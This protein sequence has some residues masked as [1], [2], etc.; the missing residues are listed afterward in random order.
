MSIVQAKNIQKT[1]GER[2]LL[3]DV[4]F[5]IGE[6]EV[7]GLVGIN[8]SGKTTLM[9]ILAGLE[10]YDSGQLMIK[11]YLSIGLL[12]QLPDPESDVNS[13]LESGYDAELAACLNYIGLEADPFNNPQNLSG[14]ERTRLS[15][16][17]FLS[18]NFDLM[19]LDEP[20]NNMD[21]DGIRATIKMLK[22]QTG[23]MLIVSHDRFFLDQM[24]SRIFELDQGVIYEYEGNY[25]DYR[26]QKAKQAEEQLHRYEAER[27]EQKKIEQAILQTKQWAE[28]AHRDSTKQDDSGLKMG[29]KE[30]KRVKARKLDQKIKSDTKRLE[31]RIKQQESKPR[32]EREV[33]FEI[34]QDNQRG[35][36][37]LEATDLAKSYGSHILF[38]HSYFYIKRGEKVAVYGPNGCGKTTL[39]RIMRQ[40]EQPDQG[41]LWI[42]SSCNPYYL[43]QQVDQ[44]PEDATLGEYLSERVGHLDGQKR[45]VIDQIGFSQRQLGQKLGSMS[46]GERMKTKLLEPILAEKDFLILDEPTNYLDLHTRETLETALSNYNGTLMIV[47]HDI[48]LLQQVCDKTLVFEDSM[49]R[50]YE[51]TFA[52]FLEKGR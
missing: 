13:M 45:A 49:I 47:S 24:V 20:T 1:F 25:S 40:L 36:R 29:V 12:R 51:D 31:R 19:L 9:R 26:R 34:S 17:R 50:R 35:K 23:S 44:L 30:N 46:L 28:K 14:G 39:V 52:E 42:S 10:S 48:Y 6:S 43:D 8:G 18:S 2:E 27:K 3:R 15:L 33:R 16:G 37:M 5:H 7:I 38:E 32:T 21:Y 22:Q 41:E 4:S 11:K